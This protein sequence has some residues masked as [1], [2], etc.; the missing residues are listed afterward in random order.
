MI[1]EEETIELI[2]QKSQKAWLIL[3]LEGLGHLLEQTKS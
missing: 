1:D 2:S 3:I